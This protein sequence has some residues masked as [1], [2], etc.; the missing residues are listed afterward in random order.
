MLA[1]TAEA[2]GIVAAETIADAETLEIDFD[3]I[4]RGHVLPTADRVVRLQRA[5]GPRQGV[6]RQDRVVPVLGQRQSPGM[7]ET[8]GFVKIVADAD[9]NEILGAHMIGPEVTELLPPLTLAQKWDLTAGLHRPFAP[10][11]G[12]EHRKLAGVSAASRRAYGFV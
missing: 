1:H 11:G 4:P 2:M 12:G 10:V 9:H 6:R 5:T 7:A 3:M 8:V